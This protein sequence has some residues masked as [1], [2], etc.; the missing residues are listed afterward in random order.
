MGICRMIINPATIPAQPVMGT[1]PV[2]NQT[3]NGSNMDAIREDRDTRFE[4]QTERMKT[5]I[6]MVLATGAMRRKHPAATAIPFPPSL[7]LK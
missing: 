7:N 3:V 6:E 1:E 2:V 5:I 4:S